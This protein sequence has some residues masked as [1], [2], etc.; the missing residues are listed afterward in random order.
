MFYILKRV[1]VTCY[2]DVSICQN[3]LKCIPQIEYFNMYKLCCCS[4][5]KSCPILC[6]PMDWAHQVPLSFT[7]SWSLLKLMSMELVMPSNYLI[8]CC[9]LLL[10]HAIFCSIKVFSSELALHIRWPKYWS[11]YPV[12]KSKQYFFFF[13]KKCFPVFSLPSCKSYFEILVWI[14]QMQIRSLFIG[15][16]YYLLIGWFTLCPFFKP[17]SL[18]SINKNIKHEEP[19]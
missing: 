11:F 6:D 8:L 10:L 1:R 4:V 16:I 7:I 12:S 19:K 14:I 13:G 17:W 5:A 9:P 18:T 15:L 2:M 3:S